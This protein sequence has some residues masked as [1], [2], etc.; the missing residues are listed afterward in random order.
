VEEVVVHHAVCQLRMQR[1]V[2]VVANRHLPPAAVAAA[3]RSGQSVVAATISS[4]FGRQSRCCSLRC[5][6]LV[7]EVARQSTRLAVVPVAAAVH[8]PRRQAAV[9]LAVDPLAAVRSVAHQLAEA[10]Q[11]RHAHRAVG[12]VADRRLR[13]AAADLEAVH[14][15][16]QAAADLVVVLRLRQAVAGRV[17]VH[18]LRLAVAG[19]VADR[20]SRLAVADLVVDRQSRL[21]VVDLVAVHQLRQVAVGLVA[22]HRSRRVAADQVA[23]HQSHQVAADQ[24]AVLQWHLV[25]VQAAA[26]HRQRHC[27]VARNCRCVAAPLGRHRQTVVAVQAAGQRAQAMRQAAVQRAVVGRRRRRRWVAAACDLSCCGNCR[28]RATSAATASRRV[29]SLQAAAD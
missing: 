22:V 19:P 14:Q 3:R 13:L 12:R 21:A 18:Q 28:D 27:C 4:S 29:A 10:L 23:A 15:L 11:N 24:A 6:R 5:R 7:V 8:A 26:A 9:P 1:L 16:H 17:V 20:Q 25:E 2:A